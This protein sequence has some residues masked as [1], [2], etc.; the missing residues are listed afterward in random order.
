MKHGYGEEMYDINTT[1]KGTFE[2][3]RKVKG[4]IFWADTFS[5]YDG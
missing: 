1:F 2:K 4:E 3:N 5:K